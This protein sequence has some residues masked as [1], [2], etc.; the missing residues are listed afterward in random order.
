MS[1][2]SGNIVNGKFIKSKTFDL[3]KY[4][5]EIHPGLTDSTNAVKA[6][7]NEV[8]WTEDAA[9][10]ILQAKKYRLRLPKGKGSYLPDAYRNAREIMSERILANIHGTFYEVPLQIVGEEP[11]Y[12]LMRPVATHNKQ[13]SDYNT[14]NGLLVISGVRMDAT[15][16]LHIL[17]D[18]ASQVAMWIGGVDDIWKFGQPIGSGGPWKNTSVQANSL[19]DCYLMTGYDKKTLTLTAD[20]DVSITVLLHI[21]SYATSPVVYRVFSL[22]AGQ[23]I[24]HEFPEGFS[25]HWLQVKADKDCVATA[26]LDYDVYKQHLKS[27]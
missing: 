12:K 22:K 6:L 15:P 9:S 11:L 27:E 10:V 20:K 19:S 3:D 17:K 13:I 24:I 2:F 7:S 21:A 23:T 25:A 5:L 26:W 8:I 16:S 1:A 18:S 4:N 14:W